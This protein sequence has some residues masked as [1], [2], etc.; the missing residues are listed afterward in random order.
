MDRSFLIVYNNLN[1]PKKLKYKT[2]LISTPRQFSLPKTILLLAKTGDVTAGPTVLI[3]RSFWTGGRR[4]GGQ[5][6]PPGQAEAA[7]SVVGVAHSRS[8]KKMLQATCSHLS[9][10][11]S[12]T[13]FR[14][15]P[16]M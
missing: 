5:G 13:H 9:S 16:S 3:M 10:I 6:R 14:P 15:P 11:Y 4:T 8:N 2:E 1:P 7:G 12:S